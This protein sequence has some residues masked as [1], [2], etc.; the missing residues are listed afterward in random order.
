MS[1]AQTVVKAIAEEAAVS[2]KASGSKLVAE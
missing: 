1:V 2:L